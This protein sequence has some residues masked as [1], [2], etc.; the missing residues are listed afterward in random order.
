MFN[1]TRDA[2]YIAGPCMAKLAYDKKEVT[3]VVVQ[4]LFVNYNDKSEQFS[5]F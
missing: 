2:A 4:I 1:Q 3:L 5:P